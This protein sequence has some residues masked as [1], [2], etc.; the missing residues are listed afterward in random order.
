M[1]RAVLLTRV[2]AGLVLVLGFTAV[3]VSE[4]SAAVAPTAKVTIHKA[5]CPTGTTGDI[6]EECHDNGLEDVDFLVTDDDGEQIITTDEDGVA[7]ADVVPG[8]VE[9]TEDPDVLD[10]YLGAYVYC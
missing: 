8:D 1:Q 4:A 6:F 5:E 10:D 2:L 7:S 9:I 3:R